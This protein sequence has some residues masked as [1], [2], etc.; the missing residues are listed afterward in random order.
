MYLSGSTFTRDNDGC[1]MLFT[2]YNK[3]AKYFTRE[4][5][6]DHLISASRPDNKIKKNKKKGEYAEFWTW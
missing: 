2:H 5:Q 4:I 3:M 6:T 1:K